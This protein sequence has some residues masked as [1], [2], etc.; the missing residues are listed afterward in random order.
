MTAA[1]GSSSPEGLAMAASSTNRSRTPEAHVAPIGA[2]LGVR[3]CLA[4]AGTRTSALDGGTD[5]VAEEGRGPRRARLELGVVLAGDEPGMVRELDHLDEAALLERARDHE[6]CLDE[7]RP[8]GVVDLVAVAMALVDDALAIGG[9]GA[10]PVLN[11]DGV[12]AEA[13]RAAEILDLLLLGQEVDHGVGRLRVHLRRVGAVEPDD[14]P[15]ELGDGDVHAEA[16]SEVR[17]VA[18]ASDAAGGDLPL[19][20]ARPEPTGNENA[21][22]ALKLPR[23]FFD[24]HALR[25]HPSHVDVRPVVDARVLQ[26]LVDGEVGV[27]ELD[28][29]ADEGDL[30]VAV[31][32]RD[33]AGKV[34]PVPQLDGFVRQAELRAGERVQALVTKRLRDEVDV[35]HVLV[36]DDGLGVDV[37]K[38]GDLV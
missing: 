33:A 30:D 14:V 37:G 5:E 38:E 35:A 4:D 22:G 8:E 20:P 7:L 31:A 6:T 13:H 10:R 12:G 16:D 29:L 25:V 17:N 1:T 26:G 23:G 21:V 19:P 34:F 24:T 28:V 2:I 15:C 11:V 32:L 9:V 3:G 36:G 27:L 18:L